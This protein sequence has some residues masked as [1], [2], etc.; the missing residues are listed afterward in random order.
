MHAARRVLQRFLKPTAMPPPH[1]NLMPGNTPAPPPTDP[2][3]GPPARAQPK[4]PLA[5]RE[6]RPL[7]PLH[8]PDSLPVTARRADIAAALRDHQVIIVSGETGS[9]K[10]TQLPKICLE[11]GR[12]RGRMIGHTQPRRL[13]ATSVAR[14]IAEELDTELG[15]WV[16]YQIRFGE[17]TSRQ[18]AIKVMTDGILLAESQRDPQLSRYDTLIIDEA[19]ERSLNIDFL[20]GFLH[21]LLARRKDLQL[22]ITSAT[23]DARKFA[24]H[25]AMRGKPAPV[26]E[27]SGRSYPVELRYRPVLREAP[28][29]EAAGVMQNGSRRDAERD[30]TDAVVDAVDEC[31]RTGSGDILVFLPGEREIRECADA[32]RKAIPKGL[33]VLP[34]YARLSQS[35]QDHIFRPRSQIRRVVLATNVAETSLTVPGI[36]FVI[37]SGL[38][39]VKRYSWRSKVEQL[40]IEA[41]S[42]ASAQQRAGRCGRTDPG[43]CIR[44]YDEADFQSRPAFT[45]PEILR[46]SLAGVILRM[47]SLGLQDIATFPFVDA[48]S[49]RAIADGHHLLQELGA[50]NEAG[51]LSPVG[52]ALARLPVDPRIAR[53]ILAAVEQ[54]CLEEVLVIASALSVQ[55]PRERPLAERDAAHAAQAR[56]R[57]DKSEFLSF[58]KLWRWCT[59]AWEER[60]SQ[61]KFADTLRQV[62]VSPLRFREWRDV[63]EQ[64]SALA[65]EHH[66]RTR[67][68]LRRK[69]Q[70]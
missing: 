67:E 6:A 35:E 32:L 53:M 5:R 59:Q 55:D 38:A 25:F 63:H 16:G 3:V 13:A 22:I 61:R 52:K 23:I 46:S 33:D 64:L 31:A 57:D 30:L 48:P 68:A 40:R 62:Y 14:R 45:D 19:H 42:Q 26:I 60:Q 20:L 4:E 36:R 51:A 44:L 8:Y 56:F 69:P 1:R 50:L 9:G 34:L 12:G 41:V 27:V 49:G 37:D 7:P 54:Q 24:A 39:R 21:Q 15:D 10:T 70:P 11:L 2:T 29:A 66:W 18:T 17:K 28:A 43:V 65:R 58:V 47:K